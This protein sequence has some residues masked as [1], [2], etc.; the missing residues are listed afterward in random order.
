MDGMEARL[1]AAW[2]QVFDMEDDELD[3]DSHCFQEGGDSVAAMRLITVAEGQKILID[4]GTI[5]DFPVLKDMASKA[6]NLTRRPRSTYPT[7]RKISTKTLSK[8]ARK[9]AMWTHSKSK[10]YFQLPRHKQTS[11]P[12]IRR[13]EIS[14]R[15]I[16]S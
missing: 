7:L 8:R 1:K 11:S 2:C 4:N 3:S 9:S 16:C 5:Y 13:M 14:C 6:K 15:R 10:T 12:S